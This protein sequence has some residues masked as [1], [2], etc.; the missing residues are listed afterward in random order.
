MLLS[1]A[2]SPQ[3]WW[4]T[5]THTDRHTDKLSGV[6]KNIIPFFKGM[7]SAKLVIYQSV[8]AHWYHQNFPSS[9]TS[10]RCYSFQ[11][12]FPLYN[13]DFAVILTIA[14]IMNKTRWLHHQWISH[15]TLLM[16]HSRNWYL[17]EFW[18]VRKC[19]WFFS[20]GMRSLI[21]VYPDFYC[22]H[23]SDWVKRD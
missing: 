23:S 2:I 15:T 1:P 13:E 18:G 19:I 3:T 16:L 14:D 17:W 5:D 21:L 22:S 7:I 11:P 20:M 12:P 10:L 6:V 8:C 9:A 4:Q